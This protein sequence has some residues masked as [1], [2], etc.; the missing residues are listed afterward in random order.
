MV[1]LGPPIFKTLLP[2]WSV[3]HQ[4]TENLTIGRFTIPII[5]NIDAAKSAFWKCSKEYKRRHAGKK[6]EKDKK[7][8]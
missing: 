6:K 5:A 4:S 7:K 1:I 3:V 8:K 2:W